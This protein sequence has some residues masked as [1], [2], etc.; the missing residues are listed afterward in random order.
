[1]RAT[2]SSEVKRS[3]WLGPL[4]R[5]FQPS[6]LLVDADERT[7][8]ST[9]FPPHGSGPCGGNPVEVRVLSSASTSRADGWNDRSR[10]PSHADR[11]TSELMVARTSDLYERVLAR[12]SRR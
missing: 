6:A 1:V 9:G 2:I 12:R 11:F 10:G 7:R 8:T 5:S 3:A 4:D